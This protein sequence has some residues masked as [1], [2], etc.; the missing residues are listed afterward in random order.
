MTAS[1]LTLGLLGVA[2]S[3][4]PD[5]IIDYLGLPP[6]RLAD[7]LVQII[8]GLYLGFGML[9]WMA[10]GSVMGG[11]YGRPF[12]IGNLMHFVTAGL[13]IW[14]RVGQ[15]SWLWPLVGVY[16]VFA[17]GFGLMLFRQP[18]PLNQRTQ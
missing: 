7:L 16:L 11:I 4:A 1:A 15:L 12:V 6:A 13:A 8:G 14:S 18:P 3:F 10:R 5:E 2:A 17:L 9:N